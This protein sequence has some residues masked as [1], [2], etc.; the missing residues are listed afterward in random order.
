M[1]LI[2]NPFGLGHSVSRGSVSGLNRRVELGSRQLGGLIQVDA[3]LHPGDTGA[4][5]ADLH[6][7]WLGVIRSGLALPTDKDKEK[8]KEKRAREHD[9]D[10]G[11]AIPARDALWVAGQLRDPQAGRPRLSRRHD[12]R[13]G[14]SPGVATASPTASVL[15][16]VLDDTPAGRSGLKSGDRLVAPND[17]PVRT[18][19]DLTD[20]LDRIPAD[21]DVTLDFLRG[22]GPGSRAPSPDPR[23]PP[24]ARL[25]EPEPVKPPIA[26]QPAS[27]SQIRRDP[28]A[29]P[30]RRRR[31]D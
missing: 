25:P 11:F 17:H 30:A 20:R 26:P 24:P 21:A 12:A 16:R 4:L 14:V 29:P 8:D 13:P 27:E 1:L 5:L 23:T 18:P 22:A 15:G 9:H 6:G 28:P 31:Q 2:G 19:T 3:A 7:G 10:L